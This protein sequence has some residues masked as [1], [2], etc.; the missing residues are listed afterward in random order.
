MAQVTYVLHLHPRCTLPQELKSRTYT[1]HPRRPP[2]L[3]ALTILYLYATMPPPCAI[4]Q[5]ERLIK[6]TTAKAECFA[7]G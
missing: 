5:Q 3:L 7:A 2:F 4:D 6:R 1:L